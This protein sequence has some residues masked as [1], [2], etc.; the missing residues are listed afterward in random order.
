MSRIAVVRAFVMSILAAIA[1]L[2]CG[3]DFEPAS[4]VTDFRLI[5]VAADKPYASP[6]ETV[7]LTTLH[8]EPFGRPLTWAWTTCPLPRDSTVNAC[9]ARLRELALGPTPPQFVL[10]GESTVDVTIPTNIL[11]GIPPAGRGNALFGVVTVV[12]PGTLSVVDLATAPETAPPFRCLE[13]GSG[14]ELPFERYAVAVKRIYIYGRDRNQNPAIAGVRWD[15]APWAEADIKEV[16]ACAFDSN[17]FGDCEGEKHDL[18]VDGE[19]ASIEAGSSELG[20]PFEETVVVQYYATEG[21]F[22]FGQRTMAEP[23][24]RWAAR[25]RSRGQTITM[26][27]VLRDSRGGVTWTSRQVRVR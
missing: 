14:A 13:A 7:H 6:G 8:H 24:T 2:A 11:D 18:A 23:K 19:P 12:C 22:E 1:V 21:A 26:W 27:F 9:L 25:S 20:T 5:A 3:S 17:N 16:G 10:G 4:R 15:G